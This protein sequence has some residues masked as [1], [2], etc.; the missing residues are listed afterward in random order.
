M[1]SYFSSEIREIFMVESALE[2][3]FLMRNGVPKIGVDPDLKYWL[4]STWTSVDA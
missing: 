3:N 4:W 2:L 1:Y